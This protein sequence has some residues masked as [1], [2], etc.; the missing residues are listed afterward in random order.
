M[1]NTSIVACGQKFD[2]GTR[3]VLWDEINGLNGYDTSEHVTEYE[4][5]KTGKTQRI[6]VKGKR[7]S[8]RNKLLTIKKLP[9]LQKKITQFFL[10]HSGLYHARDTFNVLHNQR[11]LSVHFILDDNGVLYQT[12]DLKEKAW[13]GGGNNPMSV[14]IEI[15]SRAHAGKRPDAYDKA[16]QKKY[17]VGPR[18]I[19]RDKVQ[20]MWINGFEYND[21]QYAT[22]IRLGIALVEVF[23]NIKLDFPRAKNGL[24]AQSVLAKPKAYKGIIC[25]YNSNKGKIDPISFDHYRFLKGVEIKMPNYPRCFREFNDWERR[26]WTLLKLEYECGSLDGKF[27]PKTERALKQFQADYGLK[28]DGVWGRNTHKALEGALNEKERR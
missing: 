23:P 9:Q 7:Y 8:K 10:H 5:R 13:H 1:A 25:H 17:K 27:G 18:E 19:R 24:I 22:L 4:D 3:V 20:G 16:H 6:V 12:L 2:I 14:G 11:R 26:Q 15:D 28:A 21:A